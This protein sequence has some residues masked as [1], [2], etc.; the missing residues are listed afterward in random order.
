[1]IGIT[2]PCDENQVTADSPHKWINNA[3]GSSM[4]RRRLGRTSPNTNQVSVYLSKLA[5]KSSLTNMMTSSKGSIFR[6]TGPLCGEFTDHRW[7]PHTKAS[8]AELWCFLWSVREW[9]PSKQSWGWWFD[10]PSRS[11]WCHCNEI[12]IFFQETYVWGL[13]SRR[14]FFSSLGSL[15]H[16]FMS[17][18]AGKHA[19]TCVTKR[20]F[21]ETLFGNKGSN[22]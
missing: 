15:G 1:M 17:S 16:Y 14:L 12:G 5:S 22:V 4:S 19:C 13:G 11:L 8:D 21:C 20:Y 2:R 9:K 7:I 6:A 10:T 3:E 18:Y